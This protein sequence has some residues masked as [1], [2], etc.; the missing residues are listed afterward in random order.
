MEIK[1]LAGLSQPLTKLIEVVSSGIGAVSQPYLIAKN[2][3]AKANEI[4]AISD[5]LS[6]VAGNHQLPVSY[7]NGQVDVWQK[8]EDK[9]L[10][11]ESKTSEE[12]ATLRSDYQERKR[13]NNIENVTSAAAIELASSD[14]VPTE[15]IDEDWVTRFFDSA[16][17]VSSEQMQEI[18]GKILAGEIK[19]PGQYSLKTLDFLKNLTKSDASQI[20]KVCKLALRYHQMSLIGTNDK[21]WLEEKRSIVAGDHFSLGELGLLYPT[22]LRVRLF[23][24]PEIEE[25]HLLHGS[26]ILVLNRGEIKSEVS[27]PMW[28]FTSI[29]AELLTLLPSSDDLEYLRIIGKFFVS[30]QGKATLGVVNEYS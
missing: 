6:E 20:E 8:P 25:H 3:E 11:L 7:K 23:R 29:G 27:L 16:Q 18:W 17:D 1:D 28:K 21:K 9:T 14:D 4:R 19:K 2:A 10:V 22:D 12:R 5:A 26:F 15:E 13:Q 30:Q 24:S